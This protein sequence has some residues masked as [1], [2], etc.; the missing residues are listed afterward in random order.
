M[1]DFV[2]PWDS[3]NADEKKLFSRPRMPQRRL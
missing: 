1:G 2:R 3:L